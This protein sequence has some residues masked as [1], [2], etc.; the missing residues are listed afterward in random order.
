VLRITTFD[1]CIK[2]SI[3]DFIEKMKDKAKCK[4]KFR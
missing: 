1:A 4:M 3:K 2:I